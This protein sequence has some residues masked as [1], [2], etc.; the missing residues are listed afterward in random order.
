MPGKTSFVLRGQTRDAYLDLV[1]AFPLVSIKSS[2][3]LEAA[4]Q[5]LDQLL[6]NEIL[7]EGETLYV[8]AL[9][10]LIA[11]YEDE[12]WPVLAASDADLLQQL[13]DA[14]GATQAQLSREAG[15]SRSTISEVLSGKRR[16]SRG[17]IRKLAGYFGLDPAVLAVNL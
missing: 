14:K 17:M 1:R 13:L 15:I 7:D 2:E 9:G 11:T 10:D 8:D 12:H 16:F 3:H 6:K 4:Q 5:V